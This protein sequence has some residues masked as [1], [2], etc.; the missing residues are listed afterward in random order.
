[1]IK[2][3]LFTTLLSVSCTMGIREKDRVRDC[4]IKFKAEN[5][6][7]PMERCEEIYNVRYR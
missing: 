7:R 5:L 2:F 3:I 1:V 4:T 6:D